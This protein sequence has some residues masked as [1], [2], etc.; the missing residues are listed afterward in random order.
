MIA[1]RTSL[2]R[3]VPAQ[4]L[5]DDEI[6]ARAASAWRERGWVCIRIDDIRSEWL[7]RG[8][9][10]LMNALYGPRRGTR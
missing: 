7:R 1:I 3:H 8:M 4:P 2:A 6:A 9:E 5:D 10:A